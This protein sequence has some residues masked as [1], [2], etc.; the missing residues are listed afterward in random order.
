MG[1]ASPLRARER[2]PEIRCAP[3][4]TRGTAISKRRNASCRRP[5][6]GSSPGAFAFGCKCRVE[7]ARAVLARRHLPSTT[8]IRLDA[9]SRPARTEGRGLQ[10]AKQRPVLRALDVVALNVPN[11][12]L[13]RLA[14]SGRLVRLWHRLYARP[15][16]QPSALR[17]WAEAS[18]RAPRGVVCL[19][20]VLAVHEIGTQAPFEVWLALPPGVTPPR[21]QSHCLRVVRMAGPSREEGSE[22]IE[23]EGVAVPVFTISKAVADCCKDCNKTGLDVALEAL[24]AVR[25]PRQAAVAGLS[26]FAETRRVGRV[27]R[28]YLEAFSKPP[29]GAGMGQVTRRGLQPRPQPLRDRTLALPCVDFAKQASNSS[30]KARGYSRSGSISRIVP[31]AMPI[32][33]DQSLRS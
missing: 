5:E 26:H 28:P 27:M 17:A 11:V 19:L 22:R 3:Q 6:A 18:L 29:F 24:R 32:S 30:A 31:R 4:R 2:R 1:C 7:P 10:L 14:R 15:Q 25:R 33:R 21:L 8:F 13:T 23:V 12:V 20:S 9:I 16:H